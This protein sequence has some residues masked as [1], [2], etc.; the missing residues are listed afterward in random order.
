M[1]WVS[2]SLSR[3]GDIVCTSCTGSGNAVL[4]AATQYNPFYSAGRVSA[5]GV[6]LSD[7]GRIT[8]SVV[9]RS[10]YPQGLY[11]ITF[12]IAYP[13]NNYVYTVTPIGAFVSIT[14]G[15]AAS[16]TKIS[17]YTYISA[18]TSTDCGFS[19]LHFICY[20]SLTKIT[21]VLTNY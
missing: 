2:A 7:V 19:L 4:T 14:L 1:L 16:A 11:D 18:S 3:A 10:G 21:N 5:A 9:K 17:V 8:Y 13:N 6:K 15:A 12:T 20:F